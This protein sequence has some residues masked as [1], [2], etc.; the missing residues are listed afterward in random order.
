MR[1]SSAA[2]ETAPSHVGLVGHHEHQ[3]AGFV[4]QPDGLGGPGQQLHLLRGRRRERDAV[5]DGR[6]RQ[7]AVTIEERS[8]SHRAAPSRPTRPMIR[9]DRTAPCSLVRRTL[10]EATCSPRSGR[11][12]V[13]CVASWA[14]ASPRRIRPRGPP[15][16]PSATT[17]RPR[18][19]AA[20][21]ERTCA[22]TIGAHRV[23]V[24]LP[25]AWPDA[26]ERSAPGQSSVR[27]PCHCPRPR[28]GT[29][30]ALLNGRCGSRRGG[31]PRS[32]QR[33][34][35]TAAWP[36]HPHVAGRLRATFN[37]RGRWRALRVVRRTE[38]Q[39]L[40][41]TSPE[42]PHGRA[43]SERPARLGDHRFL[44]A[45]TSRLSRSRPL[46]GRVPAG[47]PEPSTAS[48]GHDGD[49]RGRLIGS[50]LMCDSSVRSLSGSAC[51]RPCRRHAGVPSSA[52]KPTSPRRRLDRSCALA[53]RRSYTSGCI[54]AARCAWLPGGYPL[55]GSSPSSSVTP[56]R[57]LTARYYSMLEDR[58]R[59]RV[60]DTLL[61]W[62]RDAT[63]CFRRPLAR[64]DSR[65]RRRH[66][67]FRKP[68]HPVQLRTTQ[69]ATWHNDSVE[70]PVPQR[71]GQ[72]PA[73]VFSS[74]NSTY[75]DDV[76]SRRALD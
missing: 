3:R 44:V 51:C 73:M 61:A 66:P 25:A 55:H 58:T 42:P 5:D 46:T 72:A 32:R 24:P 59:R 57:R 2:I 40:T 11:L 7:H 14:A 76:S 71:P 13:G 60:D 9:D 4:E 56:T 38:H 52:V 74:A 65:R 18:P 67:P 36:V 27:G 23:P 37:S 43:D 33:C 63:R 16:P 15:G 31:E 75:L 20:L 62:R 48:S 41:C 35:V 10:G 45:A 54:V 68:S 50:D 39:L 1:S 19:L 21:A 28:A 26:G 49:P 70:P 8:P 6:C 12:Q 30:L 47:P 69:V 29:L 17:D 22:L 34:A 53:A 64:I